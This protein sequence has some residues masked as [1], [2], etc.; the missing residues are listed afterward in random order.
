MNEDRMVNKE[1]GLWFT[2]MGRIVLDD[3]DGEYFSSPDDARIMT[4]EELRSG[5]SL[6]EFERRL[7]KHKILRGL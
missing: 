3:H 1:G 2:A 4:A 7:R 5:I 6:K